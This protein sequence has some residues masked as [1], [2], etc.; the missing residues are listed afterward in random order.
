MY[1]AIKRICLSSSYPLEDDSLLA[2]RYFQFGE[3]EEEEEEERER[4]APSVQAV[5]VWQRRREVSQRWKGVGISLGFKNRF[6]K[7][8][9]K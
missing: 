1:Q 5:C 6:F 9:M 8:K 2:V 3:E 7:K 4:E